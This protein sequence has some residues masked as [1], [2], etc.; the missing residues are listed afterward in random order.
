V[1]QKHVLLRLSRV[2]TVPVILMVPEKGNMWY[3]KVLN[4]QNISVSTVVPRQV[5]Y[6][7]WQAAIVR[8][9]RTVRAKGSILRLKEESKAGIPANIVAQ[10]QTPCHLW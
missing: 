10:A 2:L 7:L 6:H 9:T 1:E 5:L 8:V 4:L 3:T